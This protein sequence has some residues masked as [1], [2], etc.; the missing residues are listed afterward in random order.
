MKH[1]KTFEGLFSRAFNKQERIGEDILKGLKNSKVTNIE[2]IAE[3]QS[4][5]QSPSFTFEFEGRKYKSKNTSMNLL[6]LK[7]SLYVYHETGALVGPL[8]ISE[9]T[10]NKI[11]LF[12]CRHFNINRYWKNV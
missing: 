11:Y 4:F 1:L 5:L 2:Q 3:E 9:S 6:E 10:C 8:L 7:G 12:L